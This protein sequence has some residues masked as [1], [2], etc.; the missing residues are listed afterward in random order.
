MQLSRDATS[1]GVLFPYRTLVRAN[2]RTVRLRV[3][4]ERGLEVTVPRGFNTARIPALLQRQKNWIRDALERVAAR[5]QLRAARDPWRPP[6]QIVLPAI[7]ARWDVCAS[8][9]AAARVTVVER[10][11][12]N[13][14]L[15]GAIE[16]EAACRRAL[17]GWVMHMAHA[18]LVPKLHAASVTLGL[19]YGRVMIRR[20]RTRW[21]SCSS[22]GTISL[23]ANLLFLQPALLDYVLTHELCHLQE[24]NHSRRFWHLV[25][26]HCP[27]YRTADAQ[28]R[29]MTGLVPRWAMPHA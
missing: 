28:L 14:L 27:D 26:Q 2:S 22:R 11:A 13:L 9:T 8:A 16:D 7:A 18:H 1:A 10:D 20:Q 29:R 15:R 5:Q 24:M 25:A 23:S 4:F 19:A 21:A 12:Q 17:S 6:V 3:T